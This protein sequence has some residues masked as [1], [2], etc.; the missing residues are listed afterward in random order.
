MNDY[1]EEL[2]RVLDEIIAILQWDGGG[3]V[4]WMTEVRAKLLAQDSS[5]PDK[6]LQAYGGMGSFSDF[7]VGQTQDA[8]G[9]PCW[10]EEYREKNDQLDRLRA[11]AWQLAKQ[12]KTRAG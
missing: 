4:N 3:W 1:Q 12:L 8:K 6:L 11:Q 7:V 9:N 2:M 10:R 5:A